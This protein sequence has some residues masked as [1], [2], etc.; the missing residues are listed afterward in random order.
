[1]VYLTT[2]YAT[3]YGSA[4]CPVDALQVIV[5]VDTTQLDAT[6][7]F[8]D[9]DFV[10][11]ALA[12][13]TGRALADVHEEV[14]ADLDG[15]RHHYADSVKSLGNLAY[16]GVIP[17]EA[18]SRYAI[19]PDPVAGRLALIVDPIISPVN[20][21]LCGEYYRQVTAWLFGD[22]ENFPLQWPVSS[23]PDDIASEWVRGR[24][25]MNELRKTIL[26]VKRGA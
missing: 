26:L 20:Y 25:E 22:L 23:L 14:R 12:H 4:R 5:E 10:A 7:F 11:Q 8:P 9:E 13:Q 24:V 19:L 21:K 2:A 1:M 17:P 6:K 18:I 16:R 3:Y 15:Y